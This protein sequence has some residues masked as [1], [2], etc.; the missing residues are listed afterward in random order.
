MTTQ[1]ANV[2]LAILIPVLVVALIIPLV[3]KNRDQANRELTKERMQKLALA[4]HSCNDA[5]NKLPPAFDRFAGMEYPASVHVHL[6]PFIQQD[7]LYNEFVQNGKVDANVVIPQFLTPLD[8]FLNQRK[9]VQ[10]FAANLRVFSDKGFHTDFR[11]RLVDMPPLAA[12]EPG[13]AA[14][15]SSFFKVNTVV[16]ATKF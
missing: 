8:P 11:D 5:H 3:Q 12:I 4:L 15:P 6:L 13:S 7:E 1:R 9:G 14:I 2:V 16:F 10:N